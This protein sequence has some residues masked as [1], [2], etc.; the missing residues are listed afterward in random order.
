[1]LNIKYLS[2]IVLL[3]FVLIL[4]EVVLTLLGIE[5]SLAFLFFWILFFVWI[6]FGKLFLKKRF[7]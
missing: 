5:E 1:M 4:I 6:L 2:G 3:I 7:Q